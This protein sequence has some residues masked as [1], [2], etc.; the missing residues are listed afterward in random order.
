MRY[1]LSKGA[2]EAKGPKRPEERGHKRSGK[3]LW[4]LLTSCSSGVER[5]HGFNFDIK[6]DQMRPIL[7]GIK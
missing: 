7:F 6:C 5:G 1:I 3:R 4:L 2:K